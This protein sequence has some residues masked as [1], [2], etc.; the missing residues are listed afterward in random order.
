MIY[1]PN[2]M[3]C[4]VDHSINPTP[5]THVKTK[6]TE[7]RTK[8]KLNPE[9][10]LWAKVVDLTVDESFDDPVARH[11]I[12]TPDLATAHYLAYGVSIAG[13]REVLKTTWGMIDK[14][15][16]LADSFRGAYRR[17]GNR[18]DRREWE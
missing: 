16:E 3:G 13:L 18:A 11:D 7:N 10:S 14:H 15:P 6:N 4:L 12:M 1:S 8:P 5:G 9:Q 2:P 17:C